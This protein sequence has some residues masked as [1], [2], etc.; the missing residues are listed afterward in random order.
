M[1]YN[2]CSWENA[3]LYLMSLLSKSLALWW[4][5]GNDKAARPL[6]PAL[7]VPHN[8]CSSIRHRIALNHFSAFWGIK[9]NKLYQSHSSVSRWVCSLS[10]VQRN[11]ARGKC[12]RILLCSKETCDGSFP[13]ARWCLNAR[14]MQWQTDLLVSHPSVSVHLNT[15]LKSFSIDKSLN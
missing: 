10:M 4:L 6:E 7:R 15:F 8:P 3:I 1:S 2:I 5:I 13:T 11:H 12:S 14:A 9:K